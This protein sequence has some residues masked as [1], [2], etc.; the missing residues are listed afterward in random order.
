MISAV[1]KTTIAAQTA[2]VTFLSL[3]LFT[4]FIDIA[5]LLFFTKVVYYPLRYL[6]NT[7]RFFGI[8]QLAT[9]ISA[10]NQIHS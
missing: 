3:H 8:Q 6:Y 2:I 1:I 5:A 10:Y 4:N 9:V 7:M